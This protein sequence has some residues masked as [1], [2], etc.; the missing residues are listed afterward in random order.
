[1]SNLMKDDLEIKS[2]MAQADQARQEWQDNLMAAKIAKDKEELRDRFAMA[3]LPTM[4][5]NSNR[6]YILHPNLITEEAYNIAD[7]MMKAREEKL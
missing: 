3:A 2:M 1:M 6:S 7:A 5:Q 4:L